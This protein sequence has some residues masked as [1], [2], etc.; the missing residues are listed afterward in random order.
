MI[1]GLEAH[2]VKPES[3]DS[4]PGTHMIEGEKNQGL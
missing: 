4:N 1:Q 2:V 3:L